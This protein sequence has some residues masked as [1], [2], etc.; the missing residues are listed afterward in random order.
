MA[1]P[2]GA[3][4]TR[5][6]SGQRALRVLPAPSVPPLPPHRAQEKRGLRP[7]PSVSRISLRPLDQIHRL[8]REKRVR[9]LEV[10]PARVRH[11]FAPTKDMIA[12]AIAGR[13]PELGPRLPRPRTF[14][15]D[16]GLKRQQRRRRS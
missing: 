14:N 13:F 12:A 5:S 7:A 10:T 2:Q 15:L 4:A 11:A 16:R 1:V 8:V 6:A 9:V 3:L